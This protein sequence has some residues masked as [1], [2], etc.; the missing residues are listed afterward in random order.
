[1]CLL[2]LKKICKKTLI[3]VHQKMSIFTY[4]ILIDV[5]INLNR[6]RLFGYKIICQLK[7]SNPAE[8]IRNLDLLMQK[9]E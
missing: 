9:N 6:R 2:W 7:I 5:P 8:F 3:K 4:L 1:M